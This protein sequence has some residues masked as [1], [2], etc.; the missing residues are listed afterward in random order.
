MRAQARSGSGRWTRQARSSPSAATVVSPTR[1]TATARAAVYLRHA[2]HLPILAQLHKGLAWLCAGLPLLSYLMPHAAHAAPSSLVLGRGPLMTGSGLLAMHHERRAALWSM[3]ARGLADLQYGGVERVA[4]ICALEKAS[5]G[6]RDRF[7]IGNR[8]QAPACRW[9][10]RRDG[11]KPLPQ[12]ET[13]A[14]GTRSRRRS[15]ADRRCRA[16]DHRRRRAIQPGSGAPFRRRR[17]GARG[18]A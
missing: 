17:A 14:A 8:R 9:V 18:A 2:K 5:S 11:P 15:H 4:R 1:R 3:P 12:P 7:S 16:G 10:P 6:A 13:A